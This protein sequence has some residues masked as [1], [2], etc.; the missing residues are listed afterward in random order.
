[1]TL[2]D[3]LR[4][5]GVSKTTAITMDHSPPH[6]AVAMKPPTRLHHSYIVVPFQT[7][8]ANQLTIWISEGHL[9]WTNFL[10]RALPH[11]RPRQYFLKAEELGTKD[12]DFYGNPLFSRLGFLLEREM[13]TD[14]GS[15]HI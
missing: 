5:D 14:Y 7:E 11:R 12:I 1:M 8:L 3:L 2:E 4:E 10:S 6:V 15:R 9:P 13:N